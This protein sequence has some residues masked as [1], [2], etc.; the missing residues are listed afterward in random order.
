M[1]A[2]LSKMVFYF[3]DHAKLLKGLLKLSIDVV[4]KGE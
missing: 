4:Y 3:E 2:E 1:I